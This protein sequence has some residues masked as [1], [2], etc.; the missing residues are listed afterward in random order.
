MY[1]VYVQ[2]ELTLEA[3]EEVVDEVWR[4]APTATRRVAVVRVDA[5][6]VSVRAFER[7]QRAA[8][9]ADATQRALTGWQLCVKL[10]YTYISFGS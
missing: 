6:D 4:A 7:H 8:A 2:R 9:P 3:G 10:M 5:E 1:D